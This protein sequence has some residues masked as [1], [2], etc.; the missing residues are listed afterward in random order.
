MINASTIDRLFKDQHGHCAHCWRPVP[1]HQVH[2]AIYGRE[3]RFAK[4][5]DMPQ[6]LQLI[7]PTCHAKHGYLSS[8]FARCC[9][10]TDKVNAGY[11]MEGW[12]ADIPMLIHDQFIYFE[13]P[14][15]NSINLM[16]DV[17]EKWRKN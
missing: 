15:R 3:K 5:L 17:G 6:N 10:W 2:H 1:P 12:H 4:W 9:A 16:W 8:W 13:K 14:E 11:D 7:C